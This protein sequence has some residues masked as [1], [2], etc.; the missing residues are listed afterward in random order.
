MIL[1]NAPE[2]Y[3]LRRSFETHMSEA[4]KAMVIAGHGVGWLPES[5]VAKELKEGKV[6]C[7]GTEAWATQLEVRIYRSI[8]NDKAVTQQI[9]TFISR[10]LTAG[11]VQAGAARVP[12]LTSGDVRLSASQPPH[13]SSE[14]IRSH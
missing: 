1:L 11:R 6:V 7:A 12:R 10:E 3:H 9:W 8:D 14:T 4:L 5:C 2:P 13:A